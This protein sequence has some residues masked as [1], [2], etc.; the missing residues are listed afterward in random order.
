MP[1][2]SR[3]TRSRACGDVKA[4]IRIPVVWGSSYAILE[5]KSRFSS[6]DSQLY[7]DD[8][9]L[10]FQRLPKSQMLIVTP[11]CDIWATYRLVGSDNEFVERVTYVVAS[12]N[13]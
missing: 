3:F 1:S 13:Y 6:A 2:R 8:A 9:F 7:S 12:D 5:F 11:P 10:C 4:C